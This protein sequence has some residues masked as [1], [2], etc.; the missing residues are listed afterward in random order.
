MSIERPVYLTE[1]GLAKLKQ[2]LEELKAAG[3]DLSSALVISENLR[4]FVAYPEV[5][6]AGAR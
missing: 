1:E 4:S 6:S 5:E 2:E 3:V